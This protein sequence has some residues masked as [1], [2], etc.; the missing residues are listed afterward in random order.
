MCPGFFQ[1]MTSNFLGEKSKDRILPTVSLYTLP[2]HSVIQLGPLS[3]RNHCWQ[4]HQQSELSC[5]SALLTMVRTAN[6]TVWPSYVYM[7][8]LTHITR[9]AHHFHGLLPEAS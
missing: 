3:F 7:T 5:R 8:L 4:Q 9:G 2:G 6:D 1:I